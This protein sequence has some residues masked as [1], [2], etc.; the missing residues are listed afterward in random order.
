MYEYRHSYKIPASSLQGNHV[1]TELILDGC[2]MNEEGTAQLIGVLQ[3]IRSLRVLD[4][5]LNDVGTKA[6][7]NFGM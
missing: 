3:N 4:L 2:G 5:S 1:L 6:A 7:T